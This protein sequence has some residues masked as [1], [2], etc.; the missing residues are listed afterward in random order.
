MK[1]TQN[2]RPGDVSIR[3][4][5]LRTAT[6]VLLTIAFAAA[7]RF[8]PILGHLVQ[9]TASTQMWQSLYGMLGLEGGTEREQ[10]ILVGI[11]IVCFILALVVQ[12]GCILCW[13]AWRGRKA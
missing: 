6:L 11:M 12:T 2:G 4:T 3:T 7:V 5:L 10:L 9:K 1:S 8:V 13:Q